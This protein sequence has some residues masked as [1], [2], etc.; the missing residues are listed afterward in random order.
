MADEERDAEEANFVDE[1]PRG[2]WSWGEPDPT[3]TAGV[4]DG[5]P[6]DRAPTDEPPTVATEVP[7]LDEPAT[8]APPPIPR[9]APP[10][11]GSGPPMPPAAPARGVRWAGVALVAALVGALA[12]GGV[13]T[14]VADGDNS[15]DGGSTTPT[16]GTNTSRIA[17]PQDIQATL[18]RVQP[19]V[20]SIRTEAFEGAQG[21]FEF[22]PTPV[23]GAGTGTL[24]SADGDVLT[25][26]HVVAGATTI[27]VTLYG[28]T[29]ARPADLRGVD[30]DA[31]LAV[32]R[33]RDTAGLADRP[34]TL[35]S[36]RDVQV[37]DAVLAIGNALA[38]PGGPTVTL[39]IVS[40]KD[41]SLAAGN[42]R[43]SSL[44]QTDAAINRGNSG[45]PLVNSAGEV[46][47]INTAVIT[48]SGDS[49]VQN[50]GFAI[51]ID[52]VKPLLDRLR[53][54]APAPPQGF[55]GVSTVTVTPEIADRFSLAADDGAIIFEIVP[56]SPAALAGL[57]PNDVVTRLGED[58]IATNADLT[59]AVRRHA[60][61]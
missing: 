10:G 26:A 52:T 14:L 37:G 57:E 31:D 30:T 40:A 12:G 6:T 43:L 27:K 59:D 51:A 8:A 32:V 56:G 54:D 3:D 19:G 53:R 47:G 33:L 42:D 11:P 36:S 46:I 34:V 4:V 39:G 7:Y 49:S 20:V 45:G 5:P 16:F 18:A 61:G 55:M 28:E 38:L 35:G 44:I 23:R 1:T 21:L 29:K 48:G 9:P 22:A 58:R 60:P 13:A 15:T 2:R 41:R 25:N 50:I 24:L 17:R